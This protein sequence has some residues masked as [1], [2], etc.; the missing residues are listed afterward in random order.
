VL[1]YA[2]EDPVMARSFTVADGK[3]TTIDLLVNPDK[4]GEQTSVC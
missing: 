2:G 4:L 3:V 1:L